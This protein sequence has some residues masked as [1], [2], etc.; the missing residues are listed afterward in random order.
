MVVG[1][2]SGAAA[3]VVIVVIIAL[4]ASSNPSISMNAWGHKASPVITS[5]GSDMSKL[6]S[7]ASSQDFG[8]IPAVTA[9]MQRDVKAANDLPQPPQA[10]RGEWSHLLHDL[11]GDTAKLV[12]AE[13]DHSLTQLAQALESFA[14]VAT[15]FTNL[16]QTIEANK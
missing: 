4:A 13:K 2:C 15:D 11:N 16:S 8:A 12:K 5:L 14:N 7:D 3:I 9:K 1:L 6:G 10:I